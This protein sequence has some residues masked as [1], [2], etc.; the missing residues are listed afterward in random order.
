MAST[1]DRHTKIAV[2]RRS[3]DTKRCSKFGYPAGE[4]DTPGSLN[5]VKV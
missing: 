3:P 2:G 1:C 4:P 5:A